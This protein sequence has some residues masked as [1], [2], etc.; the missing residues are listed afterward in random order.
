MKVFRVENCDGVGPYSDESTSARAYVAE[1]LSS[2]EEATFP[3]AQDDGLPVGGRWRYGCTDMGDLMARF[4]DFIELL[5]SGGYV[6]ATYDVREEDVRISSSGTQVAF[7][8]HYGHA[9]VAL[10]RVGPVPD[11]VADMLA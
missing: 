11:H 7:C 10:V 8:A 1:I 2:M 9:S 5:S 3:A 4:E 6:L